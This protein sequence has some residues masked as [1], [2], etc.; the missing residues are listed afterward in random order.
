MSN[1]AEELVGVWQVI[2]LADSLPDGSV[3]Y[4]FGE[5]PTGGI[6]YTADGF[7]SLQLA[8]DPRPTFAEG[9]ANATPE[10]LKNVHESYVA[11]Y[12]RYS[13]NEQEC[14]V[15]HHILGSNFP[16]M[17]GTNQVRPFELSGDNLTLK[18]APFELNGVVHTRRLRL[19]RARPPQ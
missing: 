4:Q 10:E 11:M 12:G 9:Y 2:S 17:I 5:K 8:R 6:V 1:I 16:D 7:M 14:V 15:T 13:L 19:E 18:P 3:F